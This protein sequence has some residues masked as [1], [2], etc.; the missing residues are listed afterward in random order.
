MPF[1]W[2]QKRRDF[3]SKI[4]IWESNLTISRA[5]YICNFFSGPIILSL[6]VYL[7]AKI[8]NKMPV[9]VEQV[10]KMTGSDM[11]GIWKNC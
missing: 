10:A 2:Q 4:N 11:E 1:N 3:Y 9:R 7:I 8:T 5:F 6:G